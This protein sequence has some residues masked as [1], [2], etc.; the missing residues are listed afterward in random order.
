[1]GLMLRS[2]TPYEGVIVLY[3]AD[4]L[5][6]RSA[7]SVEK[8]HHYIDL[9]P[10]VFDLMTK[11][12]V[13]E[14]DAMSV[15]TILDCRYDNKTQC[16]VAMNKIQDLLTGKYDI[17]FVSEID[18]SWSDVKHYT[19]KSIGSLA[20]ALSNLD[21][22]V[23]STTDTILNS[24]DVDPSVEQSDVISYMFFTGCRKLQ[25]FR[26][27]IDHEYKANRD[28]SARPAQLNNLKREVMSLFPYVETEGAEADDYLMQ[29]WL[30]AKEK[31]P[32]Y[33]VVIATLDKDMLQLPAWHYN[34]TK[35]QLLRIEEDEGDAFFLKQML[36]GDSADNIR[37][38]K[39]IGPKKA[40]DLWRNCDFNLDSFAEA[41]VKKYQDAYGDEW[42]DAWNLNCDLLW[43]W[44]KIPDI[45]P[46]RTTQVLDHV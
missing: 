32:N 46:Y 37:G 4:L 15:S 29:A 1:M 45:C 28:P 6:Y 43:I 3:D 18:H 2:E 14:E 25:N 23:S 31:Y 40:Q 41:V 34:W 19:E 39:G 20:Q 33:F 24:V 7:F 17:H 13:T 16:Q 10:A 8:T 30:D 9:E 38:I 12:E 27:E 5:C 11:M 44:R 21:R 36:I 26:E 22:I 35:K 42:E